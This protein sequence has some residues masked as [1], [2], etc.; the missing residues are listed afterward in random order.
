MPHHNEHIAVKWFQAFND[1]NLEA[2]LS[3]YDDNAR[4]F[5]PK[6]KIRQPETKGLVVGK[7][8]LRAWWKDSFDRLP[9][10][11]YKTLSII[12]NHNKVCMEYQ[13]QV[14]GEED[15]F[16]AEILEIENG[17]IISTKVFHG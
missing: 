7:D 3:L 14:D 6:L 13:R 2:L 16:V 9:S 11:H 12:A 10:L 8:A 4:H 1:H 17:K 5:S 15:L